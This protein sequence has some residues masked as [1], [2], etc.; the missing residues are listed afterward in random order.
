GEGDLAGISQ[1]MAEDIR[2]QI[3]Q[4]QSQIKASQSETDNDAQST[5]ASTDTEITN[6][7]I[8]T[9]STGDLIRYG[10]S[11]NGMYILLAFMAPFFNKIEDIIGYFF[12]KTELNAIVEAL[13]GKLIGSIIIVVT[14]IVSVFLLMMLISVLGSILKFHNYRLTLTDETL[15]RKSGLI[16]TQEES[17]NL[18]KIQAIARQSNFIGHWLG[19]ENL[20]CRQAGGGNKQQKRN[21]LFVVPA[22]TA[23]QSEQ[24]IE[25]LYPD[26]PEKIETHPINRRYIF[27]TLLLTLILPVLLISAPFVIQQHFWVM[28]FY[29]LPLL[30]YPLIAKRWRN[31]RYG[32]TD[33]Y[34]LIRSG[35]IG[36][37]QVLFPLFK[38]QRA[39]I[40]QSPVQKRR[41]L[42]TLTIYL[43]SGKMRIPYMPIEHARQWFDQIYAKIET[44]SRPWF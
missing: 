17:L 23:E 9:A 1:S 33:E 4:R 14:M 31:Y 2:D 7:P 8:A 15:K 25:T 39:V 13:G 22:R 38:V 11:N 35:F 36:H 37:K 40:S 20:I 19:R 29:L 10:L 18:S 28:S 5:A 3:L 12:S 21:N 43:A 6:E 30:C 44:D 16:N 42:A 34:G 41:N 26:H 24:L 32:K 27:K